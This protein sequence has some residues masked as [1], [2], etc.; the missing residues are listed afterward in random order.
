MHENA[1]F[2]PIRGGGRTPGTPYAGSAT[3]VS[4][5]NIKCRLNAI[6]LIFLHHIDSYIRHLLVSGLDHF[7]TH[8]SGHNTGLLL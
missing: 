2:S 3:E 7:H 4:C 1:I 8:R 5:C 6:N